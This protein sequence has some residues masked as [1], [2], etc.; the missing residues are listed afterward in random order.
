M[1][2]ECGRYGVMQENVSLERTTWQITF[3]PGQ[4]L[5]HLLDVRRQ[6]SPIVRIQ[7]KV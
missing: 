2:W 4:T 6:K 1:V 7:A 3:I 5:L